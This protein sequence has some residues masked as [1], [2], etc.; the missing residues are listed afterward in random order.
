MLWS[1]YHLHGCQLINKQEDAKG[2]CVRYVIGSGDYV[3]KCPGGHWNHGKEASILRDL[4][5]YIER[6]KK[7]KII[8]GKNHSIKR[9]QLWKKLGEKQ[10]LEVIR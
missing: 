7:L 5:M 8:R 9:A 1:Q 10:H 3:F 4:L 2:N 6:K